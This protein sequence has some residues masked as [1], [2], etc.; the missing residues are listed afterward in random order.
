MPNDAAQLLIG[1]AVLIV[2]ALT[3]GKLSADLFMSAARGPHDGTK[4][5]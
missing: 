2:L 5:S 1:L 3:L 4:G